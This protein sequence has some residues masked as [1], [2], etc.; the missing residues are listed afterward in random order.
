MKFPTYGYILTS[1]MTL[2][3]TVKSFYTG[4]T[5]TR[6]INDGLIKDMGQPVNFLRVKLPE[7]MDAYRSKDPFNYPLY[8]LIAKGISKYVKDL[9]P[10]IMYRN[11]SGR[12][13][14]DNRLTRLYLS[15]YDPYLILTDAVPYRDRYAG[16]GRI[17]L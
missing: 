14:K 11:V 7:G 10:E 16:Q 15:G 13:L 4:F 2:D 17:R 3:D 12:F 8:R 5:I 1:D 9:N 6:M